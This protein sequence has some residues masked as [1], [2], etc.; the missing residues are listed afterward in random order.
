MFTFLRNKLNF[1]GFFFAWEKI[2]QILESLDRKLNTLE[3]N[4]LA[5]VATWLMQRRA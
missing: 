5:T 4:G 2:L 3:Q 1:I